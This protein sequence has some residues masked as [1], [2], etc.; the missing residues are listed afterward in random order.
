MGGNFGTPHGSRGRMRV[1]STSRRVWT[2][3]EECEL[4]NALKYLVVKGNKCD[5]GFRL[6][7]TTY[8]VDALPKVWESKIKVN[9]FT[10]SLGKRAFPFYAQWGEIFGNDRAT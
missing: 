4:M 8:H 3:V 9:S 7:S 5:N 1:G 10:K 2:F 6:N